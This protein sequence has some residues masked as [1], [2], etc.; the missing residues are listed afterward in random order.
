MTSKAVFILLE[1]HS[2]ENAAEDWKADAL[3]NEE[4]WRDTPKAVR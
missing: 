1:K 3:R 2:C 4:R